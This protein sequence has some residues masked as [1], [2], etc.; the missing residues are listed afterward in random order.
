MMS[1]CSL[2]VSPF[3]QQS[4][5]PPI[6]PSIH[7]LVHPS[8]LWRMDLPGIPLGLQPVPPKPTSSLP[9]SGTNLK[10]G[11]KPADAAKA[12]DDQQAAAGDGAAVASPDGTPVNAPPLTTTGA[13]SHPPPASKEANLLDLLDSGPNTPVAAAAASQLQ[14]QASGSVG[15]PAAAGS[16]P[17]PPGAALPAAA[18]VAAAAAAGPAGLVAPSAHTAVHVSE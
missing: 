16:V 15:G 18:I 6:H 17:V 1:S 3:C 14:L 13:G 5:L 2:P 9:L 8:F 12:K 11:K 4:N 7:P 10:G